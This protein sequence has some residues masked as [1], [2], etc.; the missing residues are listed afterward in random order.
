MKLYFHLFGFWAAFL[1]PITHI[2]NHNFNEFQ[3]I[4]FLE[5]GQAVAF[6][7]AAAVVGTFVVLLVP[8]LARQNASAVITAATFVVLLFFFFTPIHTAIA[9]VLVATG[10]TTGAGATYLATIV[11]SILLPFTLKKVPILNDAVATFVLVAVLVPALG[12]GWQYIAV[13]EEVK[14]SLKDGSRGIKRVSATVSGR[15]YT[16]LS[17]ENVYYVILDEYAGA[18]AL[19]SVLGFDNTDFLGRMEKR[20]FR[21]L[22]MARSNY[23]ATHLSVASLFEMDYVMDEAAPP[24]VMAPNES[25]PASINRVAAP[26][27]IKVF[28]DAGYARAMAS[29]YIVGCKDRHFRCI[30]SSIFRPNYA[31]RT[32]LENTPA[33]RFFRSLLFADV[34]AIGPAIDA[35]DRLEAPFFLFVHHMQ[36]HWPYLFDGNCSPRH[37]HAISWSERR[38]AVGRRMYLDSI[39]CVNLMVEKL[40]ERIIRNDPAAII[41]FQADHGSG[42]LMEWDRP[43]AQWSR[44][45]VEERTSILNLVRASEECQRW[46]RHD[47]G[48]AN[49]AR[50]VVACLRR[51][52][53]YYLPERVI[54]NTGYGVDAGKAL[55][56]SFQ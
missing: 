47:L 21:H 29:N 17:G 46:L 24:N 5:I 19:R 35:L 36:P 50:F 18:G 42:F 44:E 38:D 43:L 54:L 55:E 53:P 37:R 12:I 23:I 33:V 2:I 51:Q 9:T 10:F 49:T 4:G 48:P 30:E 39:K 52:P 28:Q 20:G 7:I 11:A 41:V 26:N 3:R 34:D 56:Y 27:F 40:S 22:E 32:I 15:E 6:C 45:S 8:R 31:T 16:R 13:A 25:Y 1:W 14:P